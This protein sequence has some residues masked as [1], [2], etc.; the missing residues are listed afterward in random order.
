MR[1]EKID[2]Q[3]RLVEDNQGLVFHLATRIFRTLPVRHEYD[4]LVGYGMV[5]LTEAAKSFVPNRG[6][7]FSTFAFFR[8]RGAIF[9]GIAEGSWMTRAQYRMHVKRLKESQ[10]QDQKGDEAE[11]D[12]E[13][14]WT[15]GAAEVVELTKEHVEQ[16]ADDSD[17]T[18][19]TAASRQETAELL[20]RA[21][22]ALPRREN[23]LITLVYFEDISLKDAA[24]RLGI[25]KSWASRLH[26]KIIK[27]LGVDISRMHKEPELSE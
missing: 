9:D 16:L 4:D 23:R 19:S 1:R 5:G 20:C 27:R 24:D 21:V 14:N 3:I 10:D 12:S 25:S 17:F 7:K 11:S 13:T 18:I 8:V 26:A 6:V 2:D 22:D 15:G